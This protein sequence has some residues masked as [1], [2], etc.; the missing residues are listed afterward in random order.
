MLKAHSFELRGNRGTKAPSTPLV[1][2]FLRYGTIG[3]KR[4]N[5]K[6]PRQGTRSTVVE[7]RREQGE[8]ENGSRKYKGGVV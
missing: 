5:L 1:P 6:G 4:R 3:L 2:V 7:K 8:L